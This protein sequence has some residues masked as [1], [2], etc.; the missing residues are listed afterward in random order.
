[1]SEY[2]G[3]PATPYLRVDAARLRRNIA[4]VAES[5]AAA[6]VALRPHAKTHKCAEVT[7]L[8]LEAGAIGLTVATI[9]E[10]E[11]FVAEKNSF[12]SVPSVVARLTSSIPVV[13]GGP[14]Q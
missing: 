4:A 1:M 5:A 10:A 13:G 6:G 9:G 2:D 8:Q 12:G 3:E 7:R 11:A 14:F